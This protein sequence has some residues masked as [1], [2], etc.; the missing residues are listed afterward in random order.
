MG[1]WGGG[2][3]GGGSLYSNGTGIINENRENVRARNSFPQSPVIIWCSGRA[4]YRRRTDVGPP[5]IQRPNRPPNRLEISALPASR[6]TTSSA[7]LFASRTTVPGRGV[8]NQRQKTG[9]ASGPDCPQRNAP[10]VRAALGGQIRTLYTTYFP[11]YIV[12]L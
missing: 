6:Q 4:L 8:V 11:G 3:G 2:R 9:P 12:A 10:H 1:I 5:P 7:D